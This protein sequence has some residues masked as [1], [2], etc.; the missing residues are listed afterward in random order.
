M[1]QKLKNLKENYT[2]NIP[3][4]V[5]VFGMFFVIFSLSNIIIKRDAYQ[6]GQERVSEYL[7]QNQ[8]KKALPIHIK[9]PQFVDISIQPDVY[10]NT[11]WTTSETKASYL[12]QSALPKEDGNII[13]YGHN[14][15]EILGNIR[16]LKG[17]EVITLTLSDNSERQY[18]IVKISEVY[19]SQ[20]QYLQ[21]TTTEMLTIYTCSGLFDQKRF[22]VQ[23]IPN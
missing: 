2:L 7:K 8:E 5:I 22:I 19:P 18:K 17:N 20:T 4:I 9:I 6:S 3:N 13:I 21:P 15:R 16:A 11:Q 14:K 23:A 1:L 10:E 12:I